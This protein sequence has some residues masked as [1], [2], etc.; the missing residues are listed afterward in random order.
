MLTHAPYP[1]CPLSSLVAHNAV[2]EN[3]L[4][5]TDRLQVEHVMMSLLYR[6]PVSYAP[7][8]PHYVNTSADTRVQLSRTWQ[9]LSGLMVDDHAYSL[10]LRPSILYELQVQP[11][12]ASALPQDPATRIYFSSKHTVFLPVFGSE[13]QFHF[14]SVVGSGSVP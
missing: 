1:C 6:L 3:F 2:S 11:F 4:S 9:C 13:F 5:F 7:L 8:P 12:V 10:R 14:L